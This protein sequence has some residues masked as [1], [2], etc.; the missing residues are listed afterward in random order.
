VEDH[1][2]WATSKEFPGLQFD[3]ALTI[4]VVARSRRGSIPNFR[5]LNILGDD[6]GLFHPVRDQ[7]TNPLDHSIRYSRMTDRGLWCRSTCDKSASYHDCQKHS[8]SI[9]ATTQ[10]RTPLGIHLL[11]Q[12]MA[13]WPL[14]SRP[15]QDIVLSA[16]FPL[17]RRLFITTIRSKNP[18]AYYQNIQHESMHDPRMEVLSGA[19]LNTAHRSNHDDGLHRNGDD[20][21]AH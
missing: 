13:W 15:R 6:Y 9:T 4:R 16:Y 17:F 14:K 21:K 1:I 20:P 12:I 10:S 18:M 7:L 3:F 2:S 11:E 5:R 19:D 8:T